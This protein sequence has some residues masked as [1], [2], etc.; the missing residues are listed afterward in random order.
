MNECQR[1]SFQYYTFGNSVLSSSACTIFVEG[2]SHTMNESK[3]EDFCIINIFSLKLISPLKKYK[4]VFIED[5]TS[6]TG[7]PLSDHTAI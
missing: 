6:I 4:L 5:I 1:R 2:C 7:Q 3:D